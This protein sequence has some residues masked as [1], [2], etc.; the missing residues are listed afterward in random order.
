VMQQKRLFSECLSLTDY[1]LRALKTAGMVVVC[2]SIQVIPSYCYALDAVFDGFHLLRVFAVLIWAV[3]AFGQCRASCLPS[4]PATILLPLPNIATHSSPASH[5]P[6]PTSSRTTI[7]YCGR[8]VGMS[9][10]RPT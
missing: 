4:R 9:L 1:M 7:T 8:S 5:P 3:L 2:Q 6:C 10:V